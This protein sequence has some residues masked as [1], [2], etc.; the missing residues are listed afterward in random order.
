MTKDELVIATINGSQKLATFIEAVPSFQAVKVKIAAQEWTV[1]L[2]EVESRDG[3]YQ[4][5]KLA[6]DL[7][8]L[9]VNTRANVAIIT[10]QPVQR[11]EEIASTAKQLGLL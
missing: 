1:K 6:I 5:N 8:K 4:R 10:N 7:I 3:F 9:R 2:E 11:V